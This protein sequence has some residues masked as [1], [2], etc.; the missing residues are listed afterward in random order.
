MEVSSKR[1]RIAPLQVKVLREGL[2]Q[3][4]YPP[5][6]IH[7]QPA[8]HALAGVFQSTFDGLQSGVVRYREIRP[9]ARLRPFIKVIWLLE[10]SV[11]ATAPQRVVPD[12][13]S[14]LILNFA[15]PF[16]SFQDGQ[17]RGQPR[18]FLAGQIDGPLMLRPRGP[19]KM[20]GI[21]FRPDGA[22]RLL[23]WPMHELSGRFTSIECL[24]NTLSR[25]LDRALEGPDPV[26]A[27]EAALLS[28]AETSHSGDPLTG[29][30]VRRITLAKGG[31]DLAALARDLGLSIRQFERRFGT[32]VGLP[33]K[34]F[35]RIERFT[36]V[37]HLLGEPCRDWVDTALACGY[38][39]Q[40][41]LIRDC[42]SLS[43]TTPAVLLAEDADLA[44]HFYQRSGMS[45]SSNTTGR[46]SV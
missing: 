17:W 39:D 2:P 18:S 25:R 3:R 44:R 11:D 9:S 6:H 14:E 27:V 38:Y 10:Q 16:E 19:A 20:L 35:C 13:C 40:A 42:K 1:G 45:H 8:R 4:S 23:A 15:Q 28:V 7:E 21:R 26:A 32:A 46:V 33:P 31:V 29:E 24:N 43:G 36:N 12:G 34:V 37:F 5:P 41:H 30:A 22:A